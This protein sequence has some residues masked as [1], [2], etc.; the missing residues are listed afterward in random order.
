[1]GVEVD[2]LSADQKERIRK[3]QVKF[4]QQKKRMEF[5]CTGAAAAG[6]TTVPS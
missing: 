5:V 3:Y 2:V 1:V 6:V 4:Q